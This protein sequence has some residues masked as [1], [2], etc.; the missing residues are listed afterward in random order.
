MILHARVQTTNVWQR[1]SSFGH[2]TAVVAA[3]TLSS[4]V[5]PT[6]YL[7]DLWPVLRN[8]SR[9][10]ASFNVVGSRGYCSEGLQDTSTAVLGATLVIYFVGDHTYATYSVHNTVPLA[11]SSWRVLVNH[12]F[13]S[14]CLMACRHQRSQL[15]MV[16]AAKGGR[17]FPAW[18]KT[19]ELVGRACMLNQPTRNKGLSRAT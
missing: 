9:S 16:A 7:P 17:C 18:G 12:R 2:M 4:T 1:L 5:H 14:V 10:R 15:C 19:Y 13:S 8:S 6:H 11:V 3:V